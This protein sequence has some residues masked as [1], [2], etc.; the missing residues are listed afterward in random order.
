M[1]KNIRQT[2]YVIMMLFALSFLLTSCQTD[3]GSY[4]QNQD[5]KSP[6]ATEPDISTLPEETQPLTREAEPSTA[7]GTR[8]NT[9]ECLIPSADGV[10]TLGN[11]SVTI[12]TSNA[13]NGYIMVQYKGSVPKVK[14]QI[15]GSNNITYTYNLSSSYEAFPLVSGNG[16]YT[17]AVYE[18]IKADQYATL[19]EDTITVDIMNEFLPYLYASQYVNFNKSSQCVGLASELALSANNDLDVV[20]N[21]Y[22]YIIEN[23]TYDFDKAET[24]QSGYIP[25][26]DQ[27]LQKKN[28]I[29][30]DYAS[31][32]A[33]MLRSQRIP[34]R[35]EI[36]YVGEAYHAWISTYISDIGWVNGIIE[37]DGEK[38][39]LMDP[40][41]AANSSED[42]LR[43]FIGSGSNYVTK[44]IY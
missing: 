38:W 19:F 17:L 7:K 30:F 29:C 42:S 32:M 6:A 37:F 40:T 18:N 31:L 28:G 2:P 12:D 41:F 9:S 8:D 35:L 10:Q 1:K 25:D 21:I 13:E 4:G 20:A 44:Y 43:E 23:V 34:T 24:V 16:S 26:V 27:V 14:F 39:T 15:T 33:A 11:E 36:G 22:N 5:S 3:T